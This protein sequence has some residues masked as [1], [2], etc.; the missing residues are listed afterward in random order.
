MAVS[1]AKDS[2][3]WTAVLPVHPS[4]DI[5]HSTENKRQKTLFRDKTFSLHALVLYMIMIIVP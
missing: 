3:S 5:H 4:Q 1:P 2:C